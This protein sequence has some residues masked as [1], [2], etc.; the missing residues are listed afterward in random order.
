[1]IGEIYENARFNRSRLIYLTVLCTSIGQQLNA[2]NIVC[3][4]KIYCVKITLKPD[5]KLVNAYRYKLLN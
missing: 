1:M 2:I 3:S 4:P 5:R